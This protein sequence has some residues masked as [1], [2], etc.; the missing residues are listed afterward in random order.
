MEHAKK[1]MLVEPKLFHPSMREK[2]LTRLDEE[3]EKTLNSDLPD[4]EKAIK[5]IEALR[6]YKYYE[7]PQT[8]E[9]E[10]ETQANVKSEILSSVSGAQW[11]KAKRLLEHV[12]RHKDVEIGEKGELIYNNQKIQQSRVCDLLND[13]LQKRS[14]SILPG[15]K[16]LSDSL[17]TLNVSRALIVN[18]D[19][20]KH[21]H[22]PPPSPRGLTTKRTSPKASISRSSLQRKAQNAEGLQLTLDRSFCNRKCSSH[23]VD[24][25][26]Q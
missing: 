19:R 18:T 4:G 25:D 24:Y 22:I 3:I 11:H 2:T 14:S 21:M 23:W 15:W 6:Q 7:S 16:K 20:W 5:Y 17:K 13:I 26:E 1:L 12:K 9:K 10:Q 8:K